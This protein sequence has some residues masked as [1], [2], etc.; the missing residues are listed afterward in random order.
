MRPHTDLDNSKT[1]KLLG[2]F[3]AESTKT[4][5]NNHYFSIDGK[6]YRQVEGCPI[7]LDLSVEAASLIMLLWDRKILAKL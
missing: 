1:K 2:L 7:G 6:I 3:T 5:M 4:V